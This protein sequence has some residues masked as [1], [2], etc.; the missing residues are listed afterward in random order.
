MARRA[1]GPATL[2]VVQAVEAAH[3]GEPVL[4][5]CSG[6]ADSL[7]LAVAVT[8]LA[9]RTGCAAR[10]VVVDH[11]LQPGSAEHSE[12][13]AEQVREL[14]LPAEVATV[15]VTAGGQGPEAAAQRRGPLAR[16]GGRSAVRRC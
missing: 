11:G 12:R 9:S 2:A 10:A 8:V 7:A 16:S 5:A 3:E 14:G 15:T 4:V 13:V 1:L 6:G